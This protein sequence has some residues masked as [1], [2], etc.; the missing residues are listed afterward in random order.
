MRCAGGWKGCAACALSAGMISTAPF[1]IYPV[2]QSPARRVHLENSTQLTSQM[3][4]LS[5]ACLPT[6]LIRNGLRRREGTS[7]VGRLSG[8]S[9]P[10]PNKS[11]TP[12]FSLLTAHGCGSADP[13]RLE[14]LQGHVAVRVLSIKRTRMI[15]APQS[16]SW[17]HRTDGLINKMIQKRPCHHCFL[18]TN[19]VLLW[20]S[21]S[22]STTW[23]GQ[24]Q[25]DQFFPRLLFHLQTSLFYLLLTVSS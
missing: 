23:Q 5:M 17:F 12:G 10:P 16:A 4:A 3:P 22:S 1:M 6:V 9:L 20:I 19:L 14:S 11:S 21:C 15:T 25:E 18:P 8:H 2:S 24:G 7:S 13:C